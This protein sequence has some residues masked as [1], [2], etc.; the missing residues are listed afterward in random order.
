MK[1]GAV[2]NRIIQSYNP[3]P[4]MVTGMRLLRFV[5]ISPR[6]SRSSEQHRLI[7]FTFLPV[8]RFLVLFLP[9]VK[10]Q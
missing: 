10:A 2:S 4:W 6:R 5:F 3:Y 8:T 1:I 9:S 7:P